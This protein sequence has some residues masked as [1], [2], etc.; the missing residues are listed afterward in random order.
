M[1]CLVKKKAQFSVLKYCFS[2]IQHTRPFLIH[3]N[4]WALEL[5]ADCALQNTLDL[6]DCPLLGMFLADDLR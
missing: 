1:I 6:N 2:V 5:S 3:I 4:P